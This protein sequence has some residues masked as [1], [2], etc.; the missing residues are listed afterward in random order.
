MNLIMCGLICIIKD[1]VA[2]MI[3]YSHKSTEL[4]KIFNWSQS[5][6]EKLN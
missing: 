3:Y 5:L 1:I 4:A 6:T 2:L